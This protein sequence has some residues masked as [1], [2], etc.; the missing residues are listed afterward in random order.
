MICPIHHR[1]RISEYFHM[2][3]IKNKNSKMSN[4][5]KVILFS[6]MTYQ[7]SSPPWAIKTIAR[8]LIPWF[9]VGVSRT[10]CLIAFWT[11]S[12]VTYPFN[13]IFISNPW[14][15]FENLWKICCVNFIL[16]K[17]QKL[18][19]GNFL[20]QITIY[21]WFINIILRVLTNP[22]IPKDGQNVRKKFECRK[23]RFWPCIRRKPELLSSFNESLWLSFTWFD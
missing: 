11:L 9:Q 14:Q 20:E 5:G 1:N 22:L 19:V 18:I 6:P 10:N 4:P 13:L 17:N 23:K 21:S 7:P 12:F 2:N 8:I 15:F 3:Y 16:D